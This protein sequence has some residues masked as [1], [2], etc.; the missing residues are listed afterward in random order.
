MEAQIFTPN[1]QNLQEA[2]TKIDNK[3][4]KITHEVSRE[5]MNCDREGQFFV[6]PTL[7]EIQPGNCFKLHRTNTFFK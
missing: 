7:Y 5:L 4:S 2:T 1:P 6:K 3:R